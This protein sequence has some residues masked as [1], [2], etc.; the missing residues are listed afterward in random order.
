MTLTEFL[1]ARLD[2]DERAYRDFRDVHGGVGVSPRLVDVASKRS[3]VYHCSADAQCTVHE[4]RDD[5]CADCAAAWHVGIND[6]RVLRYLA[7]PY[8][9]HPDYREEWA[10]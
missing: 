5:E 3:V 1:L 9:G 2:E 4:S 6:D 8:A 7:R 10:L